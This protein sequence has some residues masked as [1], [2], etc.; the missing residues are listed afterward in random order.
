MPRQA[1]PYA[2]TILIVD[3]EPL[4]RAAMAGQMRAAG[5]AVLEAENG[6]DAVTQYLEHQAE[7]VALVL[8]LNMPGSRG[9]VAL[10]IIRGV[11]PDLPVILAT[12]AIPEADVRQRPIGEPEVKVMLKP[13]DGSAIVRELKLLLDLA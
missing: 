1:E 2:N 7:I 9:E 4:V 5:F 11:S 6:E 3:D 10:G 8:D 12:G 13:F